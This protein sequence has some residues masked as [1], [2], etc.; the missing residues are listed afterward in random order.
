MSENTTFYDMA[1][2]DDWRKECIRR[3]ILSQ[4]GIT[5][6]VSRYDPAGANRARRLQMPPESTSSKISAETYSDTSTQGKSIHV[7]K[8]A[9]SSQSKSRSSIDQPVSSE[10]R[11]NLSSE[12]AALSLLFVTTDDVLWIER[13]GEQLPSKEQL[14]LIASMARSIRGRTVQCTHRQFH[15]PSPDGSELNFISG[16]FID[17]LSGYLHRLIADNRYQCVIRLGF[18]EQLPALDLPIHDIPSSLAM[19]QDGAMKRHAWSVLRYLR[20]SD[21]TYGKIEAAE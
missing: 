10:L 19:L 5:P 20:C 2:D 4:F 6:L 12:E 15:W 16:E 1:S 7:D 3:A 14:R 21:G 13:L 8:D 17:I 11:S 9:V 18:C